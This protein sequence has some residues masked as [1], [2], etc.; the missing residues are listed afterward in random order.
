MSTCI[1]EVRGNA[2]FLSVH[3]D[4]DLITRPRIEAAVGALPG[5]VTEV[6]LSLAGAS[7]MDV[8]GLRLLHGLRDRAAGGDCGFAVTGLGLQPTRLLRLAAEIAPEERWED[9]LPAPLA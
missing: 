5:S 2:A 6:T 7:F 8:A 3:E 4:I 9:F 1:T